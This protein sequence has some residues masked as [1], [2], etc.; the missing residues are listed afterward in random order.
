VFGLLAVW[1]L[2]DGASPPLGLAALAGLAVCAATLARR[3]ARIRPLVVVDDEGIVDDA[4]TAGV[5]RV[6]WDEIAFAQV[7]EF[8]GQTMLGMVPRDLDTILERLPEEKRRRVHV[9]RALG[10]PPISIPEALLPMTAAELLAMMAER[11]PR[12]A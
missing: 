1:L 3:L 5:G 10:C 11:A 8:N 9:N 6:R 7:Y 12:N 2:Q 4:T